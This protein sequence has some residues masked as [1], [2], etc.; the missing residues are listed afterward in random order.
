[1]RQRRLGGMPLGQQQVERTL[2]RAGLISGVAVFAVLAG[3]FATSLLRYVSPAYPAFVG[4]PTAGVGA[5]VA[6]GFIRLRRSR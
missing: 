5:G 6:T 1:M 3:L 4:I 2:W